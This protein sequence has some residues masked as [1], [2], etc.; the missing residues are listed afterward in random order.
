[1]FLTAN[2]SKSMR[3]TTSRRT[4]DRRNSRRCRRNNIR[5]NAGVTSI[6]CEGERHVNDTASIGQLRDA[7]NPGIGPTGPIEPLL[8]PQHHHHHHKLDNDSP[9]QGD[10]V[11]RPK[12][13]V[14]EYNHP[15]QQLTNI[16]YCAAPGEHCSKT[17]D[18]P[19][20]RPQHQPSALAPRGI[21]Q[22]A[23]QQQNFRGYAL[24]RWLAEDLH[25]GPLRLIPE[26]VYP[27]STGNNSEQ[28]GERR[29]DDNR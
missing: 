18:V 6:L 23:V 26:F 24:E 10:D 12:L 9:H 20:D 3:N 14:C 4:Q 13:D 8:S 5:S 17:G 19:I 25:E 1:M 16:Y 21:E 7:S 27:A 11:E 15:T 29:G 22:S 2:Q 28:T